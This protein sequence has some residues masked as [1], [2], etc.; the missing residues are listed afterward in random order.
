MLEGFR[1]SLTWHGPNFHRD[2]CKFYRTLNDL[3][4]SEVRILLWKARRDLEGRLL[5]L[6]T[7][8]LVG[9]VRGFEIEL[10]GEQCQVANLGDMVAM[11]FCGVVT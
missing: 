6:F 4:K 1:Q 2:F 11:L 8:A 10:T 9:I 5:V 7:F 3:L